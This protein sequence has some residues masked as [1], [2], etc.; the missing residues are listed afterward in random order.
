MRIFTVDER[1]LRICLQVGFDFISAAVHPAVYITGV[2]IPHIMNDSLIMHKP[3]RIPVPEHLR[4]FIE[5]LT[6]IGFIPAA[7][8]HDARMV[9]VAFLHIL[10]TVKHSRQP[11]LG[12]R[13]YSMLGTGLSP[14]PVA[15]NI[16]F[17]NNVEPEPVTQ[18]VEFRCVRIMR[19]THSIDIQLLHFQQVLAD[20]LRGHHA[21]EAGVKFVTVHAVKHNPPAVE[22]HHLINHFKGTDA[23]HGPADFD[24]PALF[25]GEKHQQSIQIR[26]LM[27]PQVR[28]GDG[29]RQMH[30][31]FCSGTH[32][33]Y[34]MAFGIQ[35]AYARL[36]CGAQDL[37]VQFQTCPGIQVR[38]WC[39][40]KQI[41]QMAGMLQG[42]G[43]G[44]VNTGIPPEILV[45]DPVGCCILENPQAQSVAAF[46]RKGL[47][48]KPVRSKAVFRIPDKAAVQVN[49]NGSLCSTNGKDHARGFQV[50]SRERELPDTGD[51]RII[52]GHLWREQG[53]MPV[54]GI[55][56]V[57]V[58][59]CIPLR[60]L[61]L[62]FTG[63]GDREHKMIHDRVF[64]HG[65]VCLI[66]RLVKPGFPGT[67][68]GTDQTG[69]FI[70]KLQYRRKDLVIGTRV[71]PADRAYGQICQKIIGKGHKKT[72]H[73]SDAFII[74]D[75]P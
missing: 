39:A 74:H 35:Q 63:N 40:D 51:G 27:G 52:L 18:T 19:S 38:K 53:L 13:R 6:A 65:I 54:P 7:P 70:F 66:R 23:N 48:V 67:I 29:C 57:Y 43:H 60:V 59:R 37:H 24:F 21:P 64:Q 22:T 72:S 2:R 17:I 25:I 5:V 41:L 14:A 33:Q 4:E 50:L 47:Q 28:L 9:F 58:L 20:G 71:Q 30:I 34:D 36:A 55:L 12:I 31:R 45:I 11:G 68:Q 69:G 8:N 16:G 73:G 46:H 44:T 62:E 3:G 26:L 1:F 10:S 49:G 75:F 56:Y 15:F 42:Q 61:Q 32:V